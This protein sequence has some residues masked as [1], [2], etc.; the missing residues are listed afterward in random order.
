MMKNTTRNAERGIALLFTIFALLFLMAVAASLTY[1]ATIETSVNSNYRQE[2]V[3]YFGAKAGLEEARARMMLT[4]PNTINTT[5][6]PLPTAAPTT[7][8]AS[9]IYITN[10]GATANSVQPWSSTNKYADDEFCHDGYTGGSPALF[11]PQQALAPGVRCTSDG[12]ASGT[13]ILPS[14]V[15]WYT[16]YVSQL[17]FNGTSSAL[18]YKWVRISPKVNSSISYL[19]VSGASPTIANY[20]VNGSQA[21]GTLICWDGTEE[22]PLSSTATN[23]NQ[24]LTAAGSPMTNVY[25]IA[26][27]GVSPMGARKMVQAEVALNPTPPF[28]YGM[29]STSTACPAITFTGNNPSTD[30]YTTANGGTYSTTQSTTGG[31]IGTAGGVNVGN[32]N[33]G[34][35]VGV[36]GASS[37]GCASPVSI[38]SQGTM[39]GTIACPSGNA[40]A[41]YMPVAPVFSVPPAPNP[42]PP[43]T[44]A[45]PNTC[46]TITTTGHG[47][48][49]TTTTVNYSC[50][51]PGT[52][53]N[54]SIQ[55]PLTLAPGVYNINSLSMTGNAQIIVNP[56]GAVTLN[57]AGTGQTTAVAIGGNGITNDTVPNDF[58]IN[59]GGTG[60]VSIAGNGSV[61]SILNAPKATITQQGNG[62]WFGSILGGQ[63]TIGGNAFFHYDRNAALAP[64]NS[65][66]FTMVGYRE[67]AY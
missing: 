42:A 5:T 40:S 57:V 27:M 17:P 61:T 31:D 13:P 63:I 62:N 64:L 22:L 33:I 65:G 53:G 11:T 7:S 35:I 43:N 2:Q 45:T 44:S 1:M 60:A 9:V 12:T 10:P 56:P 34:G 23:C 41:C 4:D 32:G 28:I 55:G 30:S 66:Y 54:I 38:G 50:L 46:T 26:S 52:Y 47:R 58:I 29:Y 67:V 15:S 14:G 16:S 18:P 19:D 3:A 37:G 51:V 59:Y 48:N 24:M 6:T 36:V 39:G 25:L 49:T 8:N 20:N 21:A